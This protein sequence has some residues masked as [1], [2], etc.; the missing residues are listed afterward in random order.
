MCRVNARLSACVKNVKSGS[1]EGRRRRP[2]HKIYRVLHS[3]YRTSY[4]NYLPYIQVNHILLLCRIC[5]I[6][7]NN[8]I[9]FARVLSKMSGR[10]MCISLNHF[11]RLPSTHFLQR[12]K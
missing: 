4:F 11:Q 12:Q 1:C 2:E 9:N 8:R 3:Y 10:Q 7:T 6:A 5:D